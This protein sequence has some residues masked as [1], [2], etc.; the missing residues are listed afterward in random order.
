[1]TYHL[2]LLFIFVNGN[3][4]GIIYKS[5]LLFYNLLEVKSPVIFIK[6]QLRVNCE[7]FEF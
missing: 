2:F 7:M 1:L 5:Y 3:T 4:K 6:V